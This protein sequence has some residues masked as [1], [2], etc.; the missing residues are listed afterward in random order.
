VRWTWLAVIPLAVAVTSV[1]A[2]PLPSWKPGPARQ[3]IVSF[4]EGVTKPGRPSFVPPAERI[5]VFDN[6]G[7]LWSE[8]PLY[9]Q[10]AFALDRVKGLAPQYPEW[11]EQEPFRS[12]LAGDLDAVLKTGK[13]GLL[14]LVMASHAGMTTDEFAAIAEAWLQTAR[15]PKYGRPYTA[16]VYVPMLE[17][18]QYL[19]ANDFEVWIVSGG[20]IEFMRP[21]TERVYGIPPQRI[22]GSSI[23]TKYEMRDGTPAIVREPAIDFIDDKA[24]KPVGIQKFIGRR[25]I[26]AFGNSDGD[27]EM[28]EWVTAGSGPRLGM[29]LHHDDAEREVAYDRE[30]HIGRLARGLDEAS[31]RG[32][33]L[34]SMKNDWRRVFRFD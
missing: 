9:V 34:I 28:L 31:K 20:G 2:E 27:F 22:V 26:A 23:E 14:E 6:D 10:L 16:C 11:N 4:V 8:Q 1:R 25:P 13:K 12:V 18:I 5:A 21:W 30:S 24:G 19:E 15:H 33:T 7:T 29:L 3:A 32:W 17:L